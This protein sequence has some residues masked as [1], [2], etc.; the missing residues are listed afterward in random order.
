M[1]GHEQSEPGYLYIGEVHTVEVAEHLCDLSRVLQDGARRLS[2]MIERCVAP[3][4]LS[5][6]SCAHN[7]HNTHGVSINTTKTEGSQR[8]SVCVSDLDADHLLRDVDHGVGQPV[9]QTLSKV[10]DGLS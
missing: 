9:L 1:T 3:Q 6:R 10:T 4:S 8:R 7:L 2:Q 5:E